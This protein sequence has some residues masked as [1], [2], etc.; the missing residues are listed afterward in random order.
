MGPS[1]GPSC[2]AILLSQP[3]D[4]GDG[5]VSGCWSTADTVLASCSLLEAG[6]HCHLARAQS[7]LPHRVFAAR[8]APAS[9][10]AALTP[11]LGGDED[12]GGAVGDHHL[13]AASL[14]GLAG[15][16]AAPGP[17]LVAEPPHAVVEEAAEEPR[18]APGSVPLQPPPVAQPPAVL[19]PG[20]LGPEA[21]HAGPG[22][23]AHVRHADL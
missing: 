23:V 11:G 5:D 4:A 14:A 6:D 20:G 18:T 3:E 7:A 21:E 13:A 12:V 2:E 22:D 1:C 9:V 17:L 8:A 19:L 16:P 10:T 15:L